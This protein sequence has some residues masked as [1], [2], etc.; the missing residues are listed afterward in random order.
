MFCRWNWSSC[1]LR[2]LSSRVIISSQYSKF[3]SLGIG[4]ITQK[5]TEKDDIAFSSYQNV[6]P[7]PPP[8]NI[9][10][11]IFHSGLISIVREYKHD[12]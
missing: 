11:L 9:L 12:T 1:N 8:P 6:L 3:I 7:T 4:Y 5:Q 10:N 2:S